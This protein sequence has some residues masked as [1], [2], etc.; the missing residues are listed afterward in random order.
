MVSTQAAE[1]SDLGLPTQ[2]SPFSPSSSSP[3]HSLHRKHVPGSV[4]REGEKIYLNRVSV[5]RVVSL[6]LSLLTHCNIY[7]VHLLTA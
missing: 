6:N 5:L 1:P 4:G 2:S 3:G 7:K